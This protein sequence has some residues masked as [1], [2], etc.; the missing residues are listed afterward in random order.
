[1][2]IPTSNLRE[3]LHEPISAVYTEEALRKLLEETPNRTTVCVGDHVS[4]LYINILKKPPHLAIIDGKT[5]R[6]NL[7]IEWLR[8]I[9]ELYENIYR[10]GN[11][12]GT[13]NLFELREKLA[14]IP[15]LLSYGDR[16][17]VLVDG[18]EDLIT[19][20]IPFILGARL[21]Y[22]I[23][24]GQPGLG[25]VIIDNPRIFSLVVSSLMPWFQISSSHTGNYLED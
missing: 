15:I 5:M 11:P 25:T 6:G 21:D 16:V 17:L 2:L 13:I 23:V 7:D 8:I 4:R 18:E 3:F 10:V 24:Y 20:A 19:L 22:R 9:E 1:M 14:E 12:R